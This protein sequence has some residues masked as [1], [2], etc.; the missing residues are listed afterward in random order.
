LTDTQLAYKLISLQI[1]Y[2]LHLINEDMYTPQK[3][4]EM[5]SS[6]SF[7]LSAHFDFMFVYIEHRIKDVLPHLLS[8]ECF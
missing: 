6:L 5:V 1:V 8:I 3:M 2:F 7:Y 4:H